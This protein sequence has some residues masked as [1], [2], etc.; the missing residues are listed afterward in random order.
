MGDV[1]PAKLRRI[2]LLCVTGALRESVITSLGLRSMTRT[3]RV[4][5][6]ARH[7]SLSPRKANLVE[8]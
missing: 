4:L 2:V 6:S 3:L 1:G 7:T 8:A 5:S